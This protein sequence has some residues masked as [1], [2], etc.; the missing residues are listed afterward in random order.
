[1][2]F[3]TP[4]PHLLCLDINGLE[5]AERLLSTIYKWYILH[6]NAQKLMN[7]HKGPYTVE[8]Y[9]DYV[10]ERRCLDFEDWA[11]ILVWWCE[12]RSPQAHLIEQK[13]REKKN[14]SDTET[15]TERGRW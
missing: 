4:A 7:S 15:D 3:G 13:Q 2:S 10:S 8:F 5:R 6:L 9:S 14:N 1:M 12:I 11:S